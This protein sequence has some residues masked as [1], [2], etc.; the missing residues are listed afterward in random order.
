MLGE[1]SREDESDGSLDFTRRALQTDKK[2]VRISNLMI[3]GGNLPDSSVAIHSDIS[4]TKLLKIPIAL[5]EIHG[6]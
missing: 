6:P 2:C 4:L 1:L 3:V 5:L